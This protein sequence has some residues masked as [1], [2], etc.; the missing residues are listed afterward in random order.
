MFCP[1]CK[2][3]FKCCHESWIV[4]LMFWTMMKIKMIKCILMIMKRNCWCLE[5]LHIKW[6]HERGMVRKFPYQFNIQ[7]NLDCPFFPEFQLMKEVGSWTTNFPKL[8]ERLGDYTRNSLHW[9]HGN[10]STHLETSELILN[11]G[12]N[13]PIKWAK[14]KSGWK[15]HSKNA[16]SS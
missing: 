15:E 1:I 12:E 3:M 4:C 11:L 7:E 13:W 14:W 9:K 8:W 5:N 2:Y 6:C 16:S 10:K